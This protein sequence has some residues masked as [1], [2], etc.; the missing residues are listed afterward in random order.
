MGSALARF[1]FVVFVAFISCDA[2]EIDS[3]VNEFIRLRYI[4][5]YDSDNLGA[6]VYQL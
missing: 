2:N 4:V 5:R 1:E 3:F 6:F